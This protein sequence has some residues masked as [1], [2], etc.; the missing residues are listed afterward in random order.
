MVCRG[1]NECHILRFPWG[2]STNG[3]TRT[4]VDPNNEETPA[5]LV[6]NG[7]NEPVVSDS[8]EKRDA[9]TPE[10]CLSLAKKIESMPSNRSDK[11]N[12]LLDALVVATLPEKKQQRDKCDWTALADAVEIALAL[13]SNDQQFPS[14]RS[15]AFLLSMENAMKANTPLKSLLET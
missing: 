6:R 13:V 4:Q 3:P 12:R 15:S 5:D 7:Q 9:C 2:Q 14:E 1:L 10:R 11:L 8:E